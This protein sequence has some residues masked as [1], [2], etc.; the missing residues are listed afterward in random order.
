MNKD[1]IMLKK[2]DY[3]SNFNLFFGAV[4]IKSKAKLAIILAEKNKRVGQS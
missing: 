1:L 2:K 3:W 4:M